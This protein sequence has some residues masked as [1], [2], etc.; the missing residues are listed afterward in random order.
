[1][2]VGSI[3]IDDALERAEATL[4]TSRMRAD[5]RATMELL[6]VII[7]MFVE[8]FQKNSRNSS[9]PPSQDPYR[10]MAEKKSLPIR[11]VVGPAVS[12]VGRLRFLSQLRTLTRYMS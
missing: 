2:T 1:M 3:N 10:K 5:A 8:L 12:A 6:L 7:R 9:I 11:Q 4:R